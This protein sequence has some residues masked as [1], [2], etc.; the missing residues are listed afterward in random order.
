MIRCL[1]LLTTLM[2]LLAGLDV[3]LNW[4]DN[5]E[6][7]LASYEVHR[8]EAYGMTPGPSTLI[9]Q[10]LTESAFVDEDVVRGTR[11]YYLVRAVDHSG[12][13]SAPSAEVLLIIEQRRIRIQHVHGWQWQCDAGSEHS[14]DTESVLSEL[15]TTRDHR[16]IPLQALAQ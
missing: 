6:R 2:P 7:D 8:S 14:T 13:I 9:A 10:N 16:L 15:S 1:I 11:Y 12:N 4:D 5:D 3:R